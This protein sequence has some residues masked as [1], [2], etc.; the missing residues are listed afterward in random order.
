MANNITGNP[1]YLDTV[2]FTYKDLVYIRNIVWDS[3][4]TGGTD[5]LL[6][7]DNQGRTILNANNTNSSPQMTFGP[8]Q[9][10]QGFNLVTLGGGNLSV[11]IHK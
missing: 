5:V 8:F 9:W 1:W 6:I 11:I 2:G 7:L 4:P 3:V 10:V